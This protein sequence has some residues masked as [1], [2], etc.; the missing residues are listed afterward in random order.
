[1]AL[2][3]GKVFD[4]L[5]D[6][7]IKFFNRAIDSFES[8]IDVSIVH[9]AISLELMLKS[10]LV[11]EHWAFIFENPGRASLSALADGS[12][13]S[14]QFSEAIERINCLAPNTIKSDEIE[15]Y[16]EVSNHRN[17]IV[18]YTHKHLSNKKKIETIKISILKAWYY[19]HDLI[20]KKISPYFSEEQK[21]E[22]KKIYIKMRRVEN[23]WKAVFTTKEH[24]I[25]KMIEGGKKIRT[26]AL[27]KQ[28]S[29]IISTSSDRSFVLENRKCIVCEHRR[30]ELLVYCDKCNEVFNIN[31]ENA[32]CPKCGTQYFDNKK[33]YVDYEDDYFPS[34]ALCADCKEEKVYQIGE[35]FICSECYNC[36]DEL[37]TCEYCNTT[38]LGD[39]SEDSFLNGCEFCDGR[40][41]ELMERDD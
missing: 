39:E 28:N 24:I 34:Q 21:K 18:H 37:Y 30:T 20:D 15:A 9:F 3:S 33:V 7:S 38:Y 6:S 23:Y 16:I 11:Q 4:E 1:M 22:I 36:G 13:K 41:A 31:N 26:C 14:V 10:I 8:E 19:L 32:I 2:S 27:C 5:F 17:K 25:K 40:I 12:L 29:A 35:Q